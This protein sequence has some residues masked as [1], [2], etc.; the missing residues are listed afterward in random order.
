[1]PDLLSNLH[2]CASKKQEAVWLS[3][4]KILADTHMNS[5]TVV[6]CFISLLSTCDNG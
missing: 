5:Y 3:V 1:M 6:F 4:V 2:S